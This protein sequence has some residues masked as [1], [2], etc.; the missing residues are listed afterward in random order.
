MTKRKA[1]QVTDVRRSVLE[2]K[3]RDCYIA[4]VDARVAGGSLLRDA[5]QTAWRLLLD[6]FPKVAT[7]DLAAIVDD[8]R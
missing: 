1:I 6:A 3:V 8:L 7:G 4:S 2:A 5:H